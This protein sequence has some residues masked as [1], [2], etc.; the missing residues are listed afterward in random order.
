MLRFPIKSLN[1]LISLN[2]FIATE[3]AIYSDPSP[4]W[5]W[6]F[7]KKLKFKLDKMKDYWSEVKYFRWQKILQSLNTKEHLPWKFFQE[8][9]AKNNLFPTSLRLGIYDL[10]SQIYAWKQQ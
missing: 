2:Y 6:A 4:V 1:I 3:Y 7:E 5:Q 10:L 9:S 8:T